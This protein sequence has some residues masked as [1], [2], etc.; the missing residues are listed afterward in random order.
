MRLLLIVMSMPAL[1]YITGN[2]GGTAICHK[3]DGRGNTGN[4]YNLIVV[5]DRQLE[6][7]RQHAGDLIPAPNG[8]CL[9]LFPPTTPPTATTR[10]PTPTTRPPALTTTTRPPSRPTTTD[11]STPT[12][13]PLP[14]TTTRPNGAPP[15]TRPVL[16]G[17]LPASH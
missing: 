1:W 7:H 11:V 15:T 16:T 2:G 12:T 4:G 14:P 3:V 17:T 10:P 6:R 8:F 5:E 9:V 13:R